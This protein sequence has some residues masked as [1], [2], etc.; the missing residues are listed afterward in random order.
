M[1]EDIVTRKIQ[2][3]EGTFIATA[4]GFDV[5]ECRNC[6]FKHIVPIPN[7]EE[8]KNVYQHD[9]YDKEKPL[10][11]ERYQEDLDWW[12]MVYT[13]RY[14][15]LEQHLPAG[16]RC[17]L[18]VGSGPGFFLLNG[19][20]RGWQVRG[21]DPSVKAAKH[22][23]RM[24]LEV[25]NAFYSPQTAAELGTFDA[26]NLALVLEH[27]PDPAALLKLVCRHLN[28]NGIVCII[29]PNDFN[30]F[31]IVL[32]DH[33]GFNP[34]WIAPPHHINY[35]DFDS[36]SKLIER[37]GFKVVQK[38]TTFPID[39]FLLMGDNYIGNDTL[40]RICH[41]K[42]MEFEKALVNS[43]LGSL[44]SRLYSEFANEGIGREVVLYGKKI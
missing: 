28:K 22:S 11:V 26:I 2:D 19:Q 38:E 31:Q 16:Q 21:I 4:N 36:L 14:E 1:P 7:E 23:R 20:K 24:G 44:Q 15:I 30:P 8:L 5:I 29:V 42:R 39:I 40:G 37:C 9:Y 13:R 10:Y 27:I 32:R 25:E 18:D 12:N 43:G 17:L 3:H 35:F 34:W 41:K 6:G 33:L